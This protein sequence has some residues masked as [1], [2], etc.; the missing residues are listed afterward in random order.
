[1]KNAL[2]NQFRQPELC[3]GS[4][5]REFNEKF[6]CYEAHGNLFFSLNS[7]MPL[8]QPLTGSMQMVSL[9]ILWHGHHRKAW[10]P[11]SLRSGGKSNTNLVQIVL[12]SG[13]A[14]TRGQISSPVGIDDSDLMEL[15]NFVLSDSA[16]HGCI[17]LHYI[18]LGEYARSGWQSIDL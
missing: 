4:N 9:Q 5:P 13:I 1:M 2:Q 18:I 14:N 11:A 15:Q 3:V 7:F 12:T 10:V 6:R 8:K 16:C 17:A